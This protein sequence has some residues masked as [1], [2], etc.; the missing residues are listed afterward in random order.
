MGRV[1]AYRV[2]PY[3]NSPNLSPFLSLLFIHCTANYSQKAQ[4]YRK[5]PFLRAKNFANELK[6]EVRGNYFHESIL[7]MLE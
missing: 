7:V 5:V 1:N 4:S 2:E 6:K 3:S